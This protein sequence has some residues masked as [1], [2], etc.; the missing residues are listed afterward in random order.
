MNVCMTIKEFDYQNHKNGSSEY[1]CSTVSNTL[2]Y[3]EAVVVVVV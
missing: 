1:V 3:G 2:H